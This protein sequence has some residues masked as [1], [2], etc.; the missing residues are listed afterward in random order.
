MESFYNNKHGFNEE[1]LGP[2]SQ[3]EMS[4]RL[5]ELSFNRSNFISDTKSKIKKI[6]LSK[7][8]FNEK[9]LK[10]GVIDK[11]IGNEIM[12]YNDNNNS[13]IIS[14]SSI[15]NFDL[16]NENGANSTIYSSLDSAFNNKLPCAIDNNYD[17]HNFL[18]NDDRAKFK[19]RIEDYNNL[20]NK[21]K[22]MKINDFN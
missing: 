19:N 8:D 7:N 11:N 4:K 22:N 2:I 9:F 14:Y 16:Y 6:N 18:T 17:S 1:N 3:S 13:S 10:E 20:T 15:N 21:I 12:A 5:N